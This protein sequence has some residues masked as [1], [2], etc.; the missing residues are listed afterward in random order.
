MAPPKTIQGALH[1]EWSELLAGRTDQEGYYSALTRLENFVPLVSGAAA[2]CPGTEYVASVKTASAKTRLIPFIF[3]T[4]QAYILELGNLYCRFYRDRGQITSGSAAYEITTPYLTAD[5]F[6]LK[7]VQSADVMYIFH[8]DYAPRKLS[9]TGHTSWTIAE[10]NFF[11]PALSELAWEP[12]TTLTLGAVT[13]TGITFTAGAATFQSGDVNR[14]ITSGTGRATI[15]AYVS[16]TQVTCDIL[17]DFASVGPIAAASWE[18]RGS[19]SASLLAS[20]TTPA[21]AQT[22]ITAKKPISLLSVVDA[23][24]KWA[25]SSGGT[26]E[27]YLESVDG[28]DPQIDEPDKVFQNGSAMDAGTAGSLTEGQWDW[29]QNGYNVF[30]NLTDGVTYKWTLSASGTNEYY[31]EAFAGGDPGLADPDSLQENSITIYKASAEIGTLGIAQW[32]YGDN[33]ALGYSTVYIRLTDEVNPDTKASNYIKSALFTAGQFSTIHV[34]VT[35]NYG[36]Y[37]DPDAQA[38]GF[39]TA[40]YQ[41]AGADAFRSTDVGKYILM[42]NGIIKI[43]AYTSATKVTG[44]ILKELEDNVATVAWTLEE[45]A[46]SSTLGYPSCAAFHQERL[47]MAG[48]PSFPQTVWGSRSGSYEDMG[49]GANDADSVAF[50]IAAK[51]VNVIRWLESRGALIFG[52]VGGE[53]RVGSEDRR[54][55]LTPTN[56]DPKRQTTNGTADI[57]PISI[58]SAILFWQYHARKLLQMGY[59]Y[60]QNSY[61]TSGLTHFAANIAE[62]GVSQMAYQKEPHSI[63]WSVRADGQLIGLAYLPEQQKVGWFRRITDGV[64]ESVASIPGSG[65]DELWVVVKR[66]IN[67]STVR[68]VEVMAPYFDESAATYTSNN[69]LNA[70]FLDSML[71]YN[72]AAKKDMSGAEHLAGET[73]SILADGAAH[74]QKT[75]SATGTLTLDVAA[76]VV[77]IGMPY[78]PI[79]KPMRPDGG[80]RGGT[81]QAQTKKIN[82]MH[83]RF[84]RSIPEICEV[85]PDD[86]KALDA[87]THRTSEMPTEAEVPLFDGDVP[88]EYRG[89]WE[90]DARFLLK[91]T[92]P[93]PVT[94]TAIITELEVRT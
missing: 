63:V 21:G 60:D 46:W 53:W 9:R 55:I 47:C 10:I 18:V 62:G 42:L 2:V 31:L 38:G 7:F 43:T 80:V 57:E 16:T 5:L 49:K 27:Y 40:G 26:N 65:Q 58:N 36:W 8:R 89:G 32:G 1:G 14:L 30:T 25:L 4:T 51:E 39:I 44:V 59:S 35:A 72:G 67:G 50:T 28:G 12:A 79:L 86:G 64:I 20:K 33:D 37:H 56:I 61:V 69:G 83:V 23:G 11:P 15:T 6:E 87:L 48:S 77:H 34:R 91:V 66:T 22:S 13:G 54:D 90:T 17:D 94:V 29:A 68:Y 41:Q 45:E 85:G 81:G 82:N 70:K 75:V 71:T 24:F 3:S 88:I 84:Y 76:S 92:K 78:T 93:M 19:P 52:T 73:V 74:A